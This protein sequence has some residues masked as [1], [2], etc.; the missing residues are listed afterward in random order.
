MA[1]TLKIGYVNCMGALT[2][3]Q[4]MQ[5]AKA[6]LDLSFWL[7]QPMLIA[8]SRCILTNLFMRMILVPNSA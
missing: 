5:Q 4:A 6:G 8:P 7:A 2:A 3:G 1:I